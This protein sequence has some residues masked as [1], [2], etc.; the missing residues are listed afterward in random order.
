MNSVLIRYN[1]IKATPRRERTA[2]IIEHKRN[3]KME[4]VSKREAVLLG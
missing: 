1:A 2:N 4:E 3:T